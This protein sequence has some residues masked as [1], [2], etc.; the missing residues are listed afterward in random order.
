MMSLGATPGIGKMRI[1]AFLERS[2]NDE[3]K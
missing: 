3:E 1:S 2:G